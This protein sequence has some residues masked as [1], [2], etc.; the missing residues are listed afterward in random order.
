MRTLLLKILELFSKPDLEDYF[1]RPKL[2]AFGPFLT[3]RKAFEETA[4]EYTKIHAMPK[5]I[6][7]SL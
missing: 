7:N 1:H 5:R 3:N 6:Y 4:R 2:K